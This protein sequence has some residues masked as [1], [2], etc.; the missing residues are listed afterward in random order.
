MP[1]SHSKPLVEAFGP[2]TA[3]SLEAAR[4]FVHDAWVLGRLARQAKSDRE[5]LRLRKEFRGRLSKKALDLI[6]PAP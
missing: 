2:S 4:L 1:V 6:L 5:R 3:N